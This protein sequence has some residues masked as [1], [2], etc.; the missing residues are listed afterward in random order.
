MIYRSRMYRLTRPYLF[1]EARREFS[2]VAGWT[3]VQPSMASVCQADMRYYTGRRRPEAL[4]KKLPMALLHEG[5]GHVVED[6]SGKYNPGDRVVIIPNIPGYVHSPEK[7]PDPR[8][9]CP[10][11]AAGGP[12][13]NYC[14]NVLFLG[15]GL[16]GIGQSLMLHPNECLAPIPADVPDETAVLAELMTVCRGACRRGGVDPQKHIAIIGDGVLAYILALTLRYEMKTAPEN[17]L[18]IGISGEKLAHFDF[19]P[20]LNLSDNTNVLPKT[21]PDIIFECV[22]GAG[23]SSGIDLAIKIARPGASIVLMGVTEENVPVNTR[24]VL[25]KGLGLIGCSRSAPSEYGPVLEAMKNEELQ[26]LLGRIIQN[27]F[28]CAGI[29][30][31]SA[32]FQHLAEQE[33]WSKVNISFDWGGTAK[34]KA[35]SYAAALAEIKN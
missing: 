10:A 9:C 7:F 11:C 13:S 25:E 19:S 30:E 16:D 21:A 31:F 1:E 18:I 2:S 5:V 33:S 12:G 35:E 17:L 27:T 29:E 15:S 34:Q 32:V 22:G 6:P 8:Q 23:S 26:R 28:S 4:A 24:D 3:V 14:E 20:T